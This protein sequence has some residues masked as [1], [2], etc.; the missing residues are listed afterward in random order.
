MT[1][2]K[3]KVVKPHFNI[4]C[5]YLIHTSWL[6]RAKSKIIYNMNPRTQIHIAIIRKFRNWFVEVESFIAHHKTI[7]TKYISKFIYKVIKWI[8]IEEQWKVQRRWKLCEYQFLKLK[9]WNMN[10]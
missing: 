6:V 8:K 10:I 3:P 5:Q 9:T 1:L 2:N 4:I 7:N